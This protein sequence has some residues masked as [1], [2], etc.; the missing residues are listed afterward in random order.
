M[1][2]KRIFQKW[3]ELDSKWALKAEISFSILEKLCESNSVLTEPKSMCNNSNSNELQVGLVSVVDPI[4]Y[5]FELGMELELTGQ[6]GNRP[7]YII[8]ESFVFLALEMGFDRRKF[9]N[10]KVIEDNNGF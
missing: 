5:Y 3:L 1:T 10:H 6:V 9:H 2:R 4:K 8:L 7:K